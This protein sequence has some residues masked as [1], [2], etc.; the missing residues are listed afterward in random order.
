[1][2][3]LKNPLFSLGA[4]GRL[5]RAIT[6]TRRRKVDIAE[7]TPGMVDVKSY[8]QLTWRTMFLMARDLW[9]ALS[10]AEKLTWEAAGTARHMTG[11]A[12]F[13]SQAL[14]PNPGI[15]LPLLGGTMQGNIGMAGFK[16]EDLPDPAA[17][18]EADTQAARD[19]AVATHK[20]DGAAHHARYTDAEAQAEAAALIATHAA[21]PN[22]HH[23]P[24]ASYTQGARVYHNADQ[25]IPNSSLTTLAFNSERYDTDN[26]HSNITLNS[27]LTCKTAGKYLISAS[28][29]FDV[30]AVG[31]RSVRLTVNNSETICVQKA[32]AVDP[33]GSLYLPLSSIDNMAVNDYVEVRVFQNSGGPLLLKSQANYTPEFMMQRIG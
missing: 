12:Y 30:N 10:A 9:H 29:G 28:V 3:K 20:A 14:R 17:A 26:I 21:L 22:I 32:N 8:R 16:I 33:A 19:A 31:N 1:M 25:S 7:K 4:V 6:F 13:L 11:Y 15:Y 23:T 24:P 18:Q 27:R 2:V 5:T